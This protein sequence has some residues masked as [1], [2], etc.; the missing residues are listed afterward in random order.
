MEIKPPPRLV[1]LDTQVFNSYNF[2][3]NSK[4]FQTL[5]KLSQEEK[6][7][8]LLTSVTLDE[9]RAHIIEGAKLASEAVKTGINH[10]DNTRSKPTKGKEKIK[11]S[12]NSDLLYE[13]K[14]KVQE[15]VPN[16]EQIKHELLDKLEIFLQE[17]DFQKIEV[18]QVSVVDI[19]ENY[20]SGNPPFGEGKKKSEFPDAFALLALKKEA[21]DRKKIIY[22]V[23]GDSDWEKFCSSSEDLCWIGNLDELLENIIRETDSDE[24]DVCY[25]LYRDKENEIERYI[26][27]KFSDLDFSIDLSGSSL[28]EWGSEEIEVN[29]NSVYIINSSLVEIDDSDLDQPSVVFE[30]EAEVNY[31]ANVSY[32]SLEY[33]I[34]DRED[35]MY[36]GGETIDTVFTQSV[37]LNVEVMLTLSR[38]KDYSLCDADV[39]D[40]TIDPNNTLGE[41]VIDTG[42]KDDYY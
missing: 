15:L 22:V 33:A 24:V 21:K 31:D 9:L 40:I 34:Y 23:S 32:E 36:Y 6:I 29:V 5:V 25:E 2:H 16:F 13:F 3:Y 1:T 41:I 28:I 18:D 20:F 30:L 10:L 8:L 38:D 27:D 7:R 19:F 11:I 35:G 26:E 12:K 39:E 14:K 37:K 17:T 42:F 4:P